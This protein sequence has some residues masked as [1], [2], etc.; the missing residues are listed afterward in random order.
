VPSA[1]M[2]TVPRH[3]AMTGMGANKPEDGNFFYDVQGEDI[4]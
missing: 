2:G 4:I 3:I 1:V